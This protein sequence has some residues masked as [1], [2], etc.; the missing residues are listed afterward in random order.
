MEVQILSSAPLLRRDLRR[1]G[2]SP[3]CFLIAHIAKVVQIDK[4]FLIAKPIRK[5]LSI[6]GEHLLCAQLRPADQD[7]AAGSVVKLA[8]LVER[9]RRERPTCKS[10]YEK[11]RTVFPMA[12]EYKD[13]LTHTYKPV[14]TKTQML[15]VVAWRLLQTTEAGD[16]YAVSVAVPNQSEE[17]SAIKKE[18]LFSGLPTEIYSDGEFKV[19]LLLE[20]KDR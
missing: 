18:V 19:E 12:P 7:G 5:A 16:R 1:F 8:G 20:E 13:R 11:G 4:A 6:C 9:I 14:N 15:D 2:V 10:L 3:F 17:P